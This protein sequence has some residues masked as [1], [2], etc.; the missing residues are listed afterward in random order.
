MGVHYL[1]KEAIK[2]L[3]SE[4]IQLVPG[5]SMGTPAEAFERLKTGVAEIITGQI[6]VD[7]FLK[8]WER[9][10]QKGREEGLTYDTFKL[11]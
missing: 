10:W 2:A 6:T 8:D 5:L 9:L 3:S 7:E 11:D 1:V 4:E